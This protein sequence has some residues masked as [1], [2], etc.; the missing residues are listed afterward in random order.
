M[1]EMELKNL[2]TRVARRPVEVPDADAVLELSR[3][4]HAEDAASPLHADLLRFS[5]ELEP[6]SAQLGTDIAAA[7]G[8]T[9]AV[10]SHRRAS[11]RRAAPVRR[12]WRI[13]A[14]AMAA[15]LIVAVTVV[16]THRNQAPAPVATASAA[17]DRIFAGFDERNVAASK[18]A[19]GDQIFRG[20]FL[21]DEI[22]SSSR[23]HEG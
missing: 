8:A 5:R 21:P 13:A 18:P 19:Q 20:N 1:N 23:K 11:A 12:G 16:T 17:P 4:P 9:G 7:C 3:L 15:C 2:F 22:F 10:T 6:V 14:A